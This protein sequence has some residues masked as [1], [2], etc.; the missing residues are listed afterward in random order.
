MPEVLINI[1]GKTITA[2]E[3]ETI[4]EA[5]LRHGIYIPNLCYHPDLKPMGAC[6]LCLVQIEG[7]KGPV[8]SCNTMAEE[9][10]IVK[11]KTPEVERLRRLSMELILTEHPEDCSTCWRYG[12]CP[13]ESMI[14]YLSVSSGRMRNFY[15]NYKEDT[16]NPLFIRDMSRCIKCGRCVR[17]CS[18]VRGAKALDFIFQDSGDVVVKNPLNQK[19]YDQC[20]YCTACVEVCPTGA[21]QDKKETFKNQDKYNQGKYA[22]CKWGCPAE[23]D[24]PQYI[25]YVK[26]GKYEQA[27]RII[28]EKLPIPRILGYICAHPCE[29][30]CRRGF[31]NEE[32]ISIRELKKVAVE[33]SGDS[34]KEDSKI[35][36]ETGKNVAIVGAGPGGL[37]AAYYL[38]HQ[39]HQVTIYEELPEAGGMVRYGIPEFRIPR[40]VIAKEIED[41]KS[42]GI[43]IENNK[44]ISN[45]EEL[46]D[47][48]YDAILI[49]T[50]THQGTIL[51]IKGSNLKGV[52]ANLD[53]LRAA[54]LDNP[55][56][57]GEKVVVLGGGNVA[58]DCA[59]LSLRLNA[60]EVHI[61]CIESE[62]QMPASK[63]EIKQGKLEGIILHPSCSF[64]A[65][66]G[67]N[68]VVTGVKYSQVEKIEI[69]KNNKISVT[70][71]KDSEDI[72]NC[73]QVIFAIGQRPKN[74]EEF[75]LE[76]IRG[77]Y[78]RID[79]NFQC[80]EE[81]VFAVGDVVTGTK[82]VIE[83]VAAAK[84][85]ASSIDR[86]L[87]GTGNIEEN[88]IST[89]RPLG[90]IGE[91]PGFKYLK[92]VENEKTLKD[93]QAKYEA[94]R[95]L[96]CDLRECIAQVPLYSDFKMEDGSEHIGE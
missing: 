58:Y 86:Y 63:E 47:N 59:R 68:D 57:P 93:Y 39:G 23:T 81:G 25:R 8:T 51:P 73:D 15:S 94:N 55:I 50:G 17:I 11:T 40:D 42:F 66:I 89:E 60:K 1:D 30:D 3:N 35:K 21:L 87:G 95:C 6:R 83:T 75:G 2:K 43:V 64:E 13:M 22:S 49:A 44:K 7:E 14:Q 5:A 36:E 65:I 92:R 76:M 70:T 48:G 45:I 41:I 28:R 26:E 18:E 33:R 31:V 27:L 29:E 56:N 91:E 37:T 46:K 12:S 80:S 20:K 88:L 74:S 52:I 78:L 90:F 16:S 24:I 71:K 69:D 61:L 32:P 79:S 96:Q 4:L 82:T 85:A 19:E 53:F 34:W 72:I 10:M 38:R 67:E 84:K 9:G 77:N 54:R 62:E